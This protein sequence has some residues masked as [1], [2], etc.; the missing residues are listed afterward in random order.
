MGFAS[1]SLQL[2]PP[3]VHYVAYDSPGESR[4]FDLFDNGLP[5]FIAKGSNKRKKVYIRVIFLWVGDTEQV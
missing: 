5:N 3:G 1:L 2:V 4:V